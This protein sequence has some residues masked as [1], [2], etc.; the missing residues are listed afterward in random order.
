MKTWKRL[1]SG[2]LALALL[3]SLSC[4]ALAAEP[5]ETAEPKKTEEAPKP[6]GQFSRWF[7]SLGINPKTPKASEEVL[8][9]MGTAIKQSKTVGKTTVTLNAAIWNGEDLWLSFDVKS[10]DIPEEVQQYTSLTTEKCS[11]KL[12][13][14][15]WKEYTRNN[16]EEFYA[17][18]PEV[19]PEEAEKKIQ[20]ELAKGQTGSFWFSPEGREGNTLNFQTNMGWLDSRLF[21]KTRQPV[22]TLHLENLAPDDN[23][24]KVF[25]KGP[26]DFTFTVK[27][28]VPPI[29]YTGADAKITL[30]E[31]KKV[32]MRFTE[33]QIS[34]TGLSARG[35][36][37]A[38]INDFPKAG[39]KED[40]DK[41]YLG[42]LNHANIESS[43][44]L[45]LKDG[46]YVDVTQMGGGGGG[47][48]EGESFMISFG[49]D[50]PYPIDPAAVTAVNIGGTR[51]ELEKLTAAAA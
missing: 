42:D 17:N 46:D 47:G 32:P 11:L 38:P 1:A 40:P 41:L 35:E 18:D 28:Q 50:F 5:K 29:Q 31:T 21:T 9:R 26:F 44:G 43:W 51:V 2:L 34:A 3:A 14:D 8:S 27:K 30:G 23:P 33:L 39:E 48:Q 22:L 19:T 37:L 25:L 13:D 4:A 36:V 45:W 24:D 20:A 10:P 49:H 12:R 15:Q 7:S 6:A 16:L